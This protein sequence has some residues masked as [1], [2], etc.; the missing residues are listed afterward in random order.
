[1]PAQSNNG[2]PFELQE[3]KFIMI[4]RSKHQQGRI[5]S[6]YVFYL[7]TLGFFV[8]AIVTRFVVTL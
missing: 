6:D 5:K 4:N 1:M 8:A 7:A 3:Q 2:L